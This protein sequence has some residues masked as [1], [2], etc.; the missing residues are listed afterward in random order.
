[1]NHATMEARTMQRT[2]HGEPVDVVEGRQT[3]A[4]P[5]VSRPHVAHQDLRAL[6]EV[7]L[8]SAVDSVVAE[9]LIHIR[10]QSEAL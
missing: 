10:Q 2:K 3:T 7:H 1:M 4:A 8:L 9:A 5:A 6:V